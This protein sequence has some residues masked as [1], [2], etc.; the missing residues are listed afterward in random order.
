MDDGRGTTVKRNDDSGWSSDGVVLCLG[1][2][3]NKDVIEWWGEWLR[4]RWSFYSNEGCE[5]G[6]PWRVACCD[7]VDSM[8]GFQLERGD[9]RMKH[10][11]KMKGSET[12]SSSWFNG[13]EAWHSAV[14]W[15]RR[16]EEMRD[17]RGKIEETTPVGLTWILL[18]KKIKKIHHVDSAASNG[19]WRFKATMS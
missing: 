4:L 19:W 17:Q 2:R 3:Q 7:G 12:M 1:R 13:K 10:C 11:R 18:S 14:A 16:S 15:Q 8:L 9:D 6:G 5:P